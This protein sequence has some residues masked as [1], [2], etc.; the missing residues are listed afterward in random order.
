MSFAMG[1][2]SDE[3]AGEGTSARSLRYRAS[4]TER[5]RV[6]VEGPNTLAPGIA[7]LFERASAGLGFGETS[8]FSLSSSRGARGGFFLCPPR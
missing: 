1:E 5:V 7:A 3:E 8:L 6:G 2:S 4:S